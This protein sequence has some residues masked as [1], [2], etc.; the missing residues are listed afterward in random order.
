ME[1][2]KLVTKQRKSELDEYDD[3]ETRQEE[4][5]CKIRRENSSMDWEGS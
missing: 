1:T 5:A 3:I 2:R 4:R